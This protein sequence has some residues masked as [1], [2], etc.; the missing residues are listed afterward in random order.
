MREGRKDF[1]SNFPRN[2]PRDFMRQSFR[3]MLRDFLALADFPKEPLEY[4]IETFLSKHLFVST[5]W[6]TFPMMSLRKSRTNYIRNSL[7][8]F[9][10][11]LL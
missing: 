9:F 6:N 2:S 1:L 8:D 10:K 4:L 11:D 5:G 3:D 7:T